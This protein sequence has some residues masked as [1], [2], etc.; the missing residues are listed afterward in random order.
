VLAEALA[1]AVFPVLR[2]SGGS[3]YSM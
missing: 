2:H 1:R 3:R